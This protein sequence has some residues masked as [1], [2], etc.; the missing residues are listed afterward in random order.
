MPGRRT[1]ELCR[2]VPPRRGCPWRTFASPARPAT[3]R[4]S[5]RE[6]TAAVP[7]HPRPT[8]HPSVREHCKR[9]ARMPR[10]GSARSEVPRRVGD[11]RAQAHPR[12]RAEPSRSRRGRRWQARR[13]LAAHDLRRHGYGRHVCL[14][15]ARGPWAGA[16][17]RDP[18][19]GAWPP[20]WS[21]AIFD[22]IRRSASSSTWDRARRDVFLQG[23]AGRPLCR[24]GRRRFAGGAELLGDPSHPCGR[25]PRN[26][27]DRPRRP[28]DR[29]HGR[30]R[31]RGRRHRT[32]RR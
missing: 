19:P 1:G 31:R 30:V 17:R 25:R 18:G 29:D 16:R 10:S 26:G 4:P 21:H 3:T 8:S 27:V 28:R 5:G 15:P 6:G 32:R 23:A 7:G 12:P 13:L 9:L 14:D 20:R 2:T 22:R 11:R 24:R